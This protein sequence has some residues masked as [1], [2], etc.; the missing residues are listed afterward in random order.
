MKKLYLLFPLLMIV[1][2]SKPEPINYKE[3]L[4]ER[5]GIYYTQDTNEPYNGRVFTINNDGEKEEGNIKEGK[6][7]GHWTTYNSSGELIN[8][9]NYYNFKKLSSL[10]IGKKV[11]ILTNWYSNGNIKSINKYDKTEGTKFEENYNN[12]NKKLIETYIKGYGSKKVG[13]WTIWSSDGKDSSEI[14]YKDG[15]KWNGLETIWYENGQKKSQETY[16]NGQ[17]D[18]VY[19][20]WYENGQKKY[21]DTY[22][23]GKLDG[24]G[25]WW[26]ENGQ[27]FSEGTY[28]DGKLIFIKRWNEDGSVK[29]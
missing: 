15:K 19:T 26:Y 29:E 27:K 8:F 3:M 9:I 5:G 4:I 16:K 13:L 14:I 21:E 23:D 28:K 1:G 18:G 6:I 17:R 10:D 25:T 7:N 2:C 12:G 11:N 22:K 20:N 24:L